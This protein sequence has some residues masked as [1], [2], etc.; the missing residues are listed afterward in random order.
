MLEVD[1]SAQLT[2]QSHLLIWGFSYLLLQAAKDKVKIQHMIN[3]IFFI[4]Y[5]SPDF[6]LSTTLA[7]FMLPQLFYILFYDTFVFFCLLIVIHTYQ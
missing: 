2:E 5:P 7:F 4:R 6:M 1:C 3:A